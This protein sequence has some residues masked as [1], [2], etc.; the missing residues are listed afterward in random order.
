MCAVDYAFPWDR[1]IQA[2]KFQQRVDL[3]PL[4]AG[5]LADAVRSA[6]APRPDVLLPVPLARQRRAER[7]YDQG[8]LL[9]RRLPGLLG[10]AARLPARH[11]LLQ[12]VLET[13]P[14]AGLDRAE[15][16]HNLRAAFW[17]PPAAQPAVQGRHLALL[18]DVMT[19]GATL[20]EA[21]AT[22]CRAGAASVRVWVLARTP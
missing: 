19:T 20:R 9:A 1:L 12:R 22:L 4:L 15:R 16:Q 2:F 13:P 10:G 21:A 17:V 5:L 7:G 3:A 18:D 8:W 11:D 6:G 14:Q